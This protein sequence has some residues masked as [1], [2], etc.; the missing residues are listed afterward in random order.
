MS[1]RHRRV[2]YVPNEA[3]DSLQ[4]GYRRAFQNLV[5]ADLLDEVETFSL[6]RR[7]RAGGDPG[8]HR[9][10]LL[11]AV[12]RF[13]PDLLVMQHL[14][15]TALDD[16]AF[17]DLTVSG[18]PL[19]YHEAD[20]YTRWLH[21]LPAAARAAARAASVVFTV[22]SSTFAANFRRAGAR[23]VE[24]T[25]HVFDPGRIEG[26]AGPRDRDH[27]V[28][29]IAN[30]SR[31]RVRPIPSTRARVRFTE[32]AQRSLG[33]RFALYGRDW[34]GPSARGVLPYSRQSEA[35]RS[36]WLSANWDHFARE[37]RYFSDRLAISLA[38]GSIS[39]TTSHPGYDAVFPEQETGR[40]LLTA[41]SP[42]ALVDRI[43]HY[44]RTTSIEQRLDAEDAARR[45]AWAHLRQD[46]NLVM[47]LNAAGAGIDPAAA[48]AAWDPAT[49]PSTAG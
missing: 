30:R 22:G 14:G 45:F 13:Q 49:A 2:F 8:Q 47:M 4:A 48:R 32:L 25:P 19:L 28:V 42:A 41:T 6:E 31:A 7:L 38:S 16:S 21:P 12:R 33:E 11:A 24:W 1:A 23:R 34:D 17:A 3:G 18:T 44:L 37:E 5:S 46:D 40:F 9:R 26:G 20:P 27:D 43:E 39:A 36:A 15:A 10:D 35:L 29:M